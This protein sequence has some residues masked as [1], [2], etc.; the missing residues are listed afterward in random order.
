MFKV[1]KTQNANRAAQLIPKFNARVKTLA[2]LLVEPV[3]ELQN[4]MDKKGQQVEQEE[5]HRQVV[6]SMAE[7]VFDMVALVFKGIETFVFHFPSGTAAFDQVDHVVFGD[8][9]IGDPAVVIGAFGTDKE[10][11][12]EEI[13]VIGILCPV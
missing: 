11:V 10:A 7:V 9:D 2:A 3:G 6:L 5:G 8:V 12:V 13:D 1:G 4:L